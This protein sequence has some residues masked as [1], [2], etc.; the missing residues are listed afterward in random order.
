M[1]ALPH[2]GHAGQRAQFSSPAGNAKRILARD[3]ILAA[4]PIVVATSAGAG[5][6]GY[7]HFF[8]ITLPDGTP[9]T[10]VGIEL[11]D[12]RIAWSVPNVGPSVSP[13]IAAGEIGAGPVRLPIRHLYAIRPFTDDVRMAALQRDLP[14]RVSVLLDDDIAYCNEPDHRDRFC[15]SCLAFVLQVVFPGPY[16]LAPRMPAQFKRQ[17]DQLYYTTDDLLLYLS[18]IDMLPTREARQRR[19]EQMALPGALK[20]DLLELV[21]AIDPAQRSGGIQ[22]AAGQAEPPP[23]AAGTRPKARGAARR[24]GPR[25]L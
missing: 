18:G 15:M 1:L 4:A 21:G 19:V 3:P 10:Q 13:F 11:D 22:L 9:E 2:P 14:G 8:E 6:A 7:I 23:S 25:R 17:Q 24:A 12:G 5:Q 20:D 16:P